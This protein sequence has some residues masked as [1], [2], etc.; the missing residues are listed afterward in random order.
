MSTISLYSLNLFI[1]I[2]RCELCLKLHKKQA[3]DNIAQQRM[4]LFTG[5]NL[6][7]FLFQCGTDTAPIE[8]FITWCLQANNNETEKM[9]LLKWSR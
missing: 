6:N 2:H 1:I 4:I 5:E 3:Y 7:S 9:L 8:K